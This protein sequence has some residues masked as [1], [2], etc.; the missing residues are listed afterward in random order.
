MLFGLP[1]L[2]WLLLAYAAVVI[3]IILGSVLLFAGFPRLPADPQL[4]DPPLVSIVLP[5]RNQEASVQACVESLLDSDYPRKEI[6]VVEGASADATRPL[7]QPYEDRLRVVDE[8]PLPAGWVGKNW[9]CHHGFLAAK[10]D[11]LLF[12]DGD[13]VHRRRTLRRAV[14][15]LHDQ[16]LDLVTLHSRLR[17]ESFWERVI[18]PLMIFLIGLTYRG[19]RMNRPD[20]RWVVGNG[21]F[22]LFRREAYEAVGGH[23]AVAPRVDEDYRLAQRAKVLGHPL[24]MVDGRDALEVRMY[25]SLREIWGGWVKNAFPG[26]DFRLW[27]ILRATVGLFLLLVLPFLQLAWALVQLLLS[28]PTLLLWISGGLSGLIVARMAA[29]H[30][31]LGGHARFALTTPLGASLIGAM[32][33]DSARRYLGGAGVS[34][35]GRVYGMPER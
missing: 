14:A 6:I 16:G 15:Y 34:W 33:V 8:P 1:I 35:K 23:A 13:T 3:L 11:L 30:A 20:T 4:E 32:L 27:K 7:L 18:Q 28:G 21:Q 10:G 31:L 19:N 29:A 25:T 9:A 2:A 22:L 5:V 24:R 12:T 17:V 26:M